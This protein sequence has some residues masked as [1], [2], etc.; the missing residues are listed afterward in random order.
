[1]DERQER[2]EADWAD[3]HQALEGIPDERMSEPGIVDAWSVKDLIAHISFW[4]EYLVERI[5][6][7]RAGSPISRPDVDTLNADVAAERAEW[8]LRHAREHAS[9]AHARMLQELARSPNAPE[10]LVAVNTWEHY[11][12]HAA[13]IRAWRE[14]EGI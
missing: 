10:R 2:I 4:E 8:S 12:E 14:R 6:A 7:Q 1:M 13:H 5:E 11:A 9:A 3:L